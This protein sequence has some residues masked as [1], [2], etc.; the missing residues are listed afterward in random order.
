MNDSTV[1]RFLFDALDIRGAVVRLGDCWQEMQAGRDYAPPVAELLGE[2]AAVTALIAAQL[3]QPGRLT[4]QLRGDGPIKLLVMDCNEALQMRGMARTDENIAA[5]PA[6]ELLGANQG[7]HLLLTLEMPHA[8][9]PYQSIVP[10]VGDS[11][12]QIFEHYLEKSEQQASRLFLAAGPESAACLFLQKM[13]DA[14][15]RDPDGWQRLMSLAE[16][17]KPGELLSL[18]AEDLLG[19]LFH[20]DMDAHGLRLYEPHP[21]QY[22]CPDIRD[23]VRDMIISLGRDEAQAIVEEHGEIHV[24]DDICNREYRFSADEVQALFADLPNPGAMH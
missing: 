16:T 15:Q 18:N 23:K 14:D 10:M 21:V 17:V 8:R 13:P 12:A 5:A 3:K 2:M 4:F 9:E 22:H 24:R 19:R 11:V 6:P 7:G 20:E 1:R